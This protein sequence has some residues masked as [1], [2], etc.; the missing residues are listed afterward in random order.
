LSADYGFPGNVVQTSTGA[1]TTLL[2]G[3]TPQQFTSQGTGLTLADHFVGG[4]QQVDIQSNGSVYYY[5]WTSGMLNT[6]GKR[7]FPFGGAT[8]FFVQ[9][10]ARMAGPNNGSWSAVWMLPDVGGSGQEIDLQEYNVSGANPDNMYSHVQG[11]PVLVG[12]GTSAVPLCDGDHVYGLHVNS[13]THTL[14]TYLDGMQTG[15]YTGAQVGSGYFLILDA[16]VSSGQASWQTSESFVS[17][18]NADMAMGVAEIQV[19]QR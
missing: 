2:G 7:F 6:E 4:P 15:T 5:E 3:Y 13:A 10:S 1:D 11:P 8:E 14:T 18:S 19:Y 16:A 17:N 9:V 12:T